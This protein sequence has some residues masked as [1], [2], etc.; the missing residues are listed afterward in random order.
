M[1]Q[2]KKPI[3]LSNN[4][5]TAELNIKDPAIGPSVIDLANLHKETGL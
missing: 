3:T 1:P 5:Y 2:N 4:E